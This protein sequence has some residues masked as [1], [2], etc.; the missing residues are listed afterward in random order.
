MTP[1]LLIGRSMTSRRMT[2]GSMRTS[3]MVT[4]GDMTGG[5]VVRMTG[6]ARLAM[7]GDRVVGLTVKAIGL[8]MRLSARLGCLHH[9]SGVTRQ[10]MRGRGVVGGGGGVGVGGGGAVSDRARGGGEPRVVTRSL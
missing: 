6:V 5:C 8:S 3:R 7:G 9:A 2:I 1:S 4:S 10:T